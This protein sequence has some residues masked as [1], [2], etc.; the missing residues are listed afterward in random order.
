M[1]TQ[2]PIEPAL[3]SKETLKKSIHGFLSARLIKAHVRDALRR[4]I[5]GLPDQ[6]QKFACSASV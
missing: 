4:S 3:G 6:D 2:S 1:R 5:H